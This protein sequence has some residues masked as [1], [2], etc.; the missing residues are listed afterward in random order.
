MSAA[1]R[2]KYVLSLLCL[3]LAQQALAT[4]FTVSSTSDCTLA[5][6]IQAA[7]QDQAV[8][9][10]PAGAGEDTILVADNITLDAHLPA[11]A[12]RI[13]VTSSDYRFRRSISGNRAYHIFNIRDGG[14]L[15]LS[16]V[17]LIYS[18]VL[19]SHGGAINVHQGHA[20]LTNVRLANNWAQLGGGAISLYQGSTARCNLC[21][22]V[23]NQSPFGGAIWLGDANSRIVLSDS[24]VHGNSADRGGGLYIERGSAIIT[25]TTFSR[26]VAGIGQGA[27]ILA[28]IAMVTIDDAS[29]ISPGG[30]VVASA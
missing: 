1:K 18:R 11:I 2:L 23:D 26:N 9:S 19:G 24:L 8:G 22:F 3:L 28:I 10:C 20:R 30:Y 13:T 29:V 25:R 21:Q 27:D 5:D 7:N 4:E 6:A 14:H 15:T 16:L 12:S 17:N